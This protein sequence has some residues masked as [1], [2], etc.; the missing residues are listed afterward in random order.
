MKRKVMKT[1]LSARFALL[2]GVALLTNTASAQ[3][4]QTVDDYQYIAGESSENQGLTVAPNGVLFAAGLDTWWGIGLVMASSD[5]GATWSAPLDVF[6]FGGGIVSDSAGTL[7]A[8]YTGYPTSDSGMDMHWL[9]RKSSDGGASWATVED[10]DPPGNRGTQVKGITADAAGNVYV[11]SYGGSYQ[12]Q[13]CG[14][15]GVVSGPA[16]WRAR[17]FT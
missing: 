8:A 5:N 6:D 12:Q 4:W 10:Y 13:G 11:A 9:V 15:P 7:Y 3:T 14:T 16:R 17:T 2:G 1:S